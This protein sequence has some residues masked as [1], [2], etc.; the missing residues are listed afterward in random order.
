MFFPGRVY[1]L[2]ISYVFE[3]QVLVKVIKMKP[4]LKQLFEE[5]SGIRRDLNAM[6]CQSSDAQPNLNPALSGLEERYVVFSGHV[7]EYLQNIS[8]RMEVF[9][10]N[11]TT[12]MDELEANS[13]ARFD[14]LESYS[15]RN[16]LLVH[17]VG[18]EPQEVCSDVIIKL[19]SQKKV[20]NLDHRE[21]DR[22]HRIGSHREP[23]SKPRPI[24]IKFVGYGP[25]NTVF[26]NKSKLKGSGIT[27]SES[28]TKLRHQVLSEAREKYGVKNVWSLDGIIFVLIGGTK[29]RIVSLTDLAKLPDADVTQNTEN[30]RNQ[31]PRDGHENVVLSRGRYHG[32]SI[33]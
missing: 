22:A 5:M 30:V 17:G 27:V 6:K 19:L 4:E 32:R 25:R 23:G 28:L 11:V 12:R 18:E 15:R 2:P 24:I 13:I 20:C 29:H 7:L 9:E 16:C 31:T 1:F 10:S 33:D 26:R 21:I 8:A 14:E 3:L